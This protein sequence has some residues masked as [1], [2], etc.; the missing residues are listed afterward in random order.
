[1]PQCSPRLPENA[2]FAGLNVFFIAFLLRC[3]RERHSSCHGSCQASIRTFNGSDK[4][5][6]GNP[7]S[8]AF[9]VS[10]TGN[11]PLTVTNSP[12]Q[13]KRVIYQFT[14]TGTTT[15][16]RFTDVSGYKSNA[17]WIDGVQVD[18][19]APTNTTPPAIT[20][21]DS[22]SGIFG[23]TF[24]YQITAT[25]SPTSYGAT[26]LP[27]GLSIATSSG[28]ISG[29]V[30]KAGANQSLSVAFTPNDPANYKGAAATVSISVTPATLLIAADG[31]SKVYGAGL[32]AL[33]ASYTGFVNGET[34]SV[35]DTAV[36]I[37]PAANTASAVGTYPITVSGA[38]DANYAI[39]FQPG[40]LTVTA[41]ALTITADDKSNVYGA[42]LPA[43][44]RSRRSLLIRP[45]S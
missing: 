28:L 8:T 12:G 36:Q 43:P 10:A 17:S 31:K 33:I 40:T 14:A 32:P 37:S 7:T 21:A 2:P 19:V 5:S 29:T 6:D 41:A 24:S 38:V 23:A 39:V 1:M 16:L 9:T 22:A 35:L 34:S 4:W 11:S 27:A 13:E 30:A 42:A 18:E 15:T 45:A 3:A 26:G 20:S 44:I 25:G